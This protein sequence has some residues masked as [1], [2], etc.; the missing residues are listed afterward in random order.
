[1]LEAPI[2]AGGFLAG[3]MTGARWR[4]LAG[5]GIMLA[6]IIL[7]AR[8]VRDTG[9]LAAIALLTTLM[10]IGWL[11]QFTP[12]LKVGVWLLGATSAALYLAQPGTGAVI[13]L[14]AAVVTAGLRMPLRAGAIAAT[15]LSTAFLA[16]MGQESGWT[17]FTNLAFTGFGFGFAYMAS[18]SVRR[19]REERE[20]AQALVIELQR[21]RQLELERAALTE[22]TRL[23]RE[24]HDVLAHTLSALAV[25]LEGTR[26]LV[27][28]RPGDPVV[29]VAVERAHRLAGEG[30][31]EARRAIGALR[32]DQ[33]PGPDGLQ[34]LVD[35]FAEATGTPS[36]F[37]TIGEPVPLPSEAQLALYRTAQEALTNVRKHAH[38][39]SSVD[40]R[41]RYAADGAELLV[42]DAVPSVTANG[43]AST[44]GFGLVG[45]RER[46]ELA[47]GTLEAGPLPTGFRVR[48]WLPK[49]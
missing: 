11:L 27:E 32:G 7:P 23:A 38:G 21:T 13:G 24:I 28:Q 44:G 46:A 1:M 15:A 42:E 19:I 25:Q 20:T 9:Q 35:E 34:R 14:I 6:A 22:R 8:T 29:V 45:M 4:G 31:T 17:N 43:T 49:S 2:R 30:L 47:G 40:V 16:L 36:H 10:S 3:P 12:W 33:L 18:S 48:L 39:A 37:E 41:L 26:M 5:L